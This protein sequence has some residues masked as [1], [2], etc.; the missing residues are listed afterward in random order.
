MVGPIIEQLAREYSGRIA[1]GKLNVDDNP[2]ISAS[3]GV[4]SIPTMIMFR[5][6][7]AVDVMIGAM[8]KG[9]IETKLK[10][11]LSGNNS[12]SSSLYS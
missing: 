2:R 8:P 7:K 6:G 5:S 12:S 3:F 1:F 10:Q 11:Q 4:Q 9:Q